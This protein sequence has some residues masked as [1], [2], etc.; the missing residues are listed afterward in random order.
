MMSLPLLLPTP[1][2]ALSTRNVVESDHIVLYYPEILTT[3]YNSNQVLSHYENAYKAFVKTYG[4]DTY[5][6]IKFYVLRHDEFS[7]DNP[8]AHG[9]MTDGEK[10]YVCWDCAKGRIIPHSGI[11]AEMGHIFN[12]KYLGPFSITGRPAFPYLWLD[13]G[14][15]N[16]L[17]H[18][19]MDEL[20]YSRDSKG[21]MDWLLSYAE[22]Y[23]AGGQTW[24]SK[25]GVYQP[26]TVEESL[27]G[28]GM[29][30]YIIKHIFDNFGLETLQRF[31]TV[32]DSSRDNLYVADNEIIIYL[33]SKTSGKNLVS[34]FN[35]EWKFGLNQ[36]LSTYRQNVVER[37]AFRVAVN[38]VNDLLREYAN[39]TNQ[40]WSSKWLDEQIRLAQQFIETN[41][42][43]DSFRIADIAV[44]KIRI[45]ASPA[46]RALT[47]AK[48][49]LKEARAENITSAASE[50]LLDRAML[51]FDEGRFSR[52]MDLAEKMTDAICTDRTIRE[53][54][55]QIGQ[56]SKDGR[57]Q[58]LQTAKDLL[59]RAV[60]T[61]DSDEFLSAISLAEQAI[62]LA[63]ASS[64]PITDE[65][66]RSLYVS[67]QTT[68]L[69]VCLL[70]AI[71]GILLLSWR[72]VASRSGAGVQQRITV[73]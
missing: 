5:R 51:E 49:L 44:R 29:S 32:I 62:A 36:E 53:A 16:F 35:D 9:G 40:G 22:K 60:Q 68:I 73:K 41:N 50:K 37:T 18:L 57:T 8:L 54:E 61:R 12:N 2:S 11:L 14:L 25:W 46:M 42:N 63:K 52:A 21:S 66:G 17:K 7:T 56:A 19:V 67:Q 64:R 20:G 26:E 69:V 71:L 39:F 13:E 58:G 55:R 48:G 28:Y 47:R 10:L 30:V 65:Q 1:L 27:Q 6:K 43:L 33:L 45:E 72:L 31:F 4:G 15:T 34:L 38:T 24:V 23:V 70:G 59:S 3:V